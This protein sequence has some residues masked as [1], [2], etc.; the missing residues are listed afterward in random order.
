MTAIAIK[1][2]RG[3][4]PRYSDRLLQPNQAT[5][6]WNCRI[7]SGRLDPI[8]G[9]ALVT[10]LGM[11][12]VARTIYRYRH[13]VNGVPTDNWLAW[14]SDVDVRKSPLANDERGVFYFTSEDFEPRVSSYALAISGAAYPNAWYALGVPSP[15]AAPTV[16]PS[17][18]AAP[19]ENR[20]YAYTF[21]TAWGEESGPSPASAVVSGNIS[22]SWALSGMQTDPPNSGTVSA[23]VANTPVSG[24]VRITLDSVFGL[25]PHEG[26]TFAGVVGMTDLNGTHRIVSVDAALKRVVVA[27]DT[28]QVYTADG[29]WARE[30]PLNTTGMVKRIYRTA[31]T[32]PSFLFVAEIPVA[33]TTY[34][35]TVAPTALGEVMESLSTLPPPKNLTCFRVLPNGCG[36]GLAGNELCFSDPYK[37]YSWP[38]SNRYSFSGI[39]VS[40]VPAGNSVIVLTDSYPIL[41][42]GSDPEAMSPSTMETYAPCVSKRGV[43]DVGGG[44]L[45][46]SFEGL[47]LA[48]PGMVKKLNQTIYREREWAALNP[49]TF[50][51]SFFDGQYIAH[52][53]VGGD[54]RLWMIDIAEP[55]SA[56][57]VDD[58]VNALYRNEFDGNLYITKG[59]KIYQWDADDSFRY[60][61]DWLSREYQLPRPTTFTCAQV[62]AEFD[63]IVPADTSQQDEN[64]ALL[65]TPMMGGGQ[66]AGAEILATEIGGSLLAPVEASSQRKVQFTLYVDGTPV[67]TKL[68]TNSRPF[69]LPAGYR[70]ELFSVQLAASVPTYSVAMASS[71]EE[72]RELAP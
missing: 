71:M 13:F 58:S 52:R 36:V 41:F 3:M 27:L 28:A 55:D 33:D 50:E 18:G 59:A 62:F 66:I 2:F 30:S 32:N 4:V 40:I 63:D 49:Q 46:P 9:P 12:G 51:A 23:A 10:T 6:A 35:D 8:L 68:V 60:E 72:L 45:Y 65:A 61:S 25:A 69:R 17:G 70:S 26:I 44:A 48:T 15:T 64:T 5:R 39:G 14:A 7:T 24:Q 11:S 67:F 31:G 38:I 34:T 53:D 37:L 43:A 20:A 19:A 16:A 57:E 54:S 1:G 22:G 21:V 56:I 42:T 47:W 29:T